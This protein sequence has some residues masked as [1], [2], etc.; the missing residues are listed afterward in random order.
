MAALGRLFLLKVVEMFVV[1][2]LPPAPSTTPPAVFHHVRNALPWSPQ[3]H[4]KENAFAGANPG[5]VTG[6]C[7]ELNEGQLDDDADDF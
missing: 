4:G 2:R 6:A 7:L 5:E 3:E 1:V